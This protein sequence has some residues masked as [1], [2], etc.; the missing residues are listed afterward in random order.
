M[1]KKHILFIHGGGDD[2]NEAY[3]ADGI[4]ADSLRECL[5]NDYVV[6]FP[7]M[8]EENSPD[9]GWPRQ[10]SEEVNKIKGDIILVGHSLGGSM[11]LK[12]LS[13]MQVSKKIKAVFL[14]APP[15]WTGNED[16]KQ[17]LKL[18]NDFANKLPEGIP[19]YLYQCTDDDVVPLAHHTWYVQQLPNAT[20]HKIE[21]GGHQFNDDLA[22]LAKD[23]KNI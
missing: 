21:K 16:W 18:K 11:T 7:R 17:G 4:L 3:K 6:S 8:K 5:G 20:V 9:F 10:I 23:I 22:F 13:E 2:S 14:L 15:H 19:L 12:Y 1:R